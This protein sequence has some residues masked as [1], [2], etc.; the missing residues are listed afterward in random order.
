MPNDGQTLLLDTE[1]KLYHG[2]DINNANRK[3]K[4][5]A[6]PTSNMLPFYASLPTTSICP[7]RW[8]GKKQD[9]TGQMKTKGMLRKQSVVLTMDNVKKSSIDSKQYLDYL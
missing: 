7:T 4:S 9:V 2:V 5:K 8:I 6:S 1:N 3:P